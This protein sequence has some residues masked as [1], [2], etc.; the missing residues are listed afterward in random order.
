MDR[1]LELAV[2]WWS[3]TRRSRSRPPSAINRA[4]H[5]DI[6]AA[7]EATVPLMAAPGAS[8]PTKGLEPAD[9][10]SALV[11]EPAADPRREEL[12]RIAREGL[13]EQGFE[14]TG[15]RDIAKADGILGGS[16]TTTST[17]S[18]RCWPR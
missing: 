6:H 15:I 14:S 2:C 1:A 17:P 11:S 8:E 7:I 3:S 4:S 10:G 5:A 13:A 16:L 18:R 12:L 9:L